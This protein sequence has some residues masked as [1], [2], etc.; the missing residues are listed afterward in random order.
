MRKQVELYDIARQRVRRRHR[1]LIIWAV[2]LAGFLALIGL[3]SLLEGTVLGQ[4][5][6][7]I[8]L[9]AVGLF[10]LHT[11]LMGLAFAQDEEV[12]EEVGRLRE[13]AEKA[14]ERVGAGEGGER[15]QLAPPTNDKLLQP[16]SSTLPLAEPLSPRER[17]V[18]AL[19]VSGASNQEIAEQLV[20]APNTVKRHVKHILAK[21]QVSNRT[22]A[23][24]R[25][26]EL[27]LF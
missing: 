12:E 20:I 2:H 5:S 22:E 14:I 8:L 7:F 6:T 23:V 11:L 21:L 26:Y 27:N 18:L 24:I 16:P 19:L 9:T 1:R 15:P 10:V 25:A 4:Y 17:E 3:L 13:S